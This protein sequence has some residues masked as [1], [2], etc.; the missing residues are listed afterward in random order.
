MEMFLKSDGEILHPLL[1]I[2]IIKE[3]FDINQV[4]KFQIIQETYNKIVVKL[5][6]ENGSLSFPGESLFNS[7]KNKIKSVMG[8]DCEIVFE[9]VESIPL[10]KHGKH[11]YT[12]CNINRVV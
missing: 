10:T 6:F 9:K 11:L 8:N 5:V 12:V 2:N 7:V 4:K 1:F 3:G